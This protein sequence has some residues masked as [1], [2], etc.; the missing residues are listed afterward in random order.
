MDG[1]TRMSVKELCETDDLATSLVLDPLLGF[2]THKMNISPPPEVRRWGNLKET[3]LRFQRTHDFKA[4]FEALTVGELAGDYFNSLGSHRQE[5][6]RQHVYRYLSAFLLDSGV[7]I[8]SCDRYSSETNGAKIT[9]T[10]HW[11]VGERVEVLLGC[12]AELSPADSAVLRAG[13]NDFS[14][15]YSTRKRC[16][17]LWLGPAAFINHGEPFVPGEKNGAC[18]EVI[19]P[20]SPGEEITC[21][22]GASFF[23]EGNEM[24]ECCTCERRGEGHFR[25]RGKQPEC[26]ETKDSVGQKYRLRERYLR[27]NREKGHCPTR[28]TIPGVHS[29]IPSRNSFTQ[30]MK[31]NALMSSFKSSTV[32]QCRTVP[33]LSQ[34][35]LR[36]V[37]IKV[38]RHTVDFLLNCKDPK[39]KERALLQLLE[40]VKPKDKELNELHLANEKVDEENTTNGKALGEVNLKPFTLNSSVSLHEKKAEKTCEDKEGKPMLRGKIRQSQRIRPVTLTAQAETRVSRFQQKQGRN[41]EITTAEGNRG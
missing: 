27:Q 32:K 14:V 2:S 6:L 15:M 36:D 10:R 24:C 5:L 26:E 40:E 38:R 21:Y 7:K 25:H 8:E 19:R 34:V 30:Q 12:I 18:V 29:A 4:T 13:V 17:Q 16:A 11:F 20:I 39:S 3:L 41:S 37:R 35:T 23:G 33:L 28:P 22:Y 31:R 1:C 9:A